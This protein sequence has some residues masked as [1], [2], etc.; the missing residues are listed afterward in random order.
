MCFNVDPSF[1]NS[2]DVMIVLR[3]KDFPPA[4]IRSF[5]RGMPQETQDKVFMNFYGKVDA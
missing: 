2:L 3:L 1:S 4:S 5:V